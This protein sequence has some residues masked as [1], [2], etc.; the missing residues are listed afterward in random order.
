MAQ[1][2]SDEHTFSLRSVRFLSAMVTDVEEQ[3]AAPRGSSYKM[4]RTP[5]PLPESNLMGRGVN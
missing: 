3:S 4:G 5:E 1:L 2:S